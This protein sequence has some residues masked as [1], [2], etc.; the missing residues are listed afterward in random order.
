[1]RKFPQGFRCWVVLLFSV[2]GCPFGWVVAGDL[3]ESFAAANRNYEDG[4]YTEA[5]AQ[6]H[7]LLS[8]VRNP[9]VYYNLGNA[10]FKQKDLGL[11]LLNYERA[12]S[13]AP[14]D[15][16]IRENLDFARSL[17]YDRIVIPPPPAPMGFLVWLDRRFTQNSATVLLLIAYLGS[18][19]FL[20]GFL[21]AKP[22]S[23]RKMYL[24]GMTVLAIGSL[25]LGIVLG[26]KFY[27]SETQVHAIILADSVDVWSGP[28]EGRTV[29][30]TVHEGL[31]ARV[32]G[33]RQGWLQVSLP[34]GW[35]GW[36]PRESAG[37]I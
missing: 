30:F 22:G 20:T 21:L 28:G 29:L 37:I 18:S 26:A 2:A 34:N 10:Y 6:Y 12:L 32:Q 19:G 5:V 35:N 1:M 27:L 15:R 14:G 17:I 9:L 33:Q 8:Q 31:R 25:I 7:T 23:W 3:E 16:Q 4:R 11:A 13:L 24:Y 36:I